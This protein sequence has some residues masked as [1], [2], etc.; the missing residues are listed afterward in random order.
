MGRGSKTDMQSALLGKVADR[1]GWAIAGWRG[2]VKGCV[3]PSQSNKVS[4]FRNIRHETEQSEKSQFGDR[5]Y[6]KQNWNKDGGCE[7]GKMGQFKTAQRHYYCQKKYF[8]R[9]RTV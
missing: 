1:R 9:K 5:W 8:N 7:W 6:N 4:L 2:R 3:S